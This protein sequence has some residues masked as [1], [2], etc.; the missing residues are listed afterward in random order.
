MRI[1]GIIK[2][3]IDVHTMGINNISSHLELCGYKVIKSNQNIEESTQNI[4][5]DHNYYKIEK[6]LI[7]NEIT[8]LCF[9]YRLDQDFGS[10]VFI[11]LV[12]K[13]I[14]RNLFS[15]NE[16]KK[17]KFLYFAGLVEGCDNITQEFRGGIN[18][19]IGD[20]DIVT[21]LKK[22][23]IPDNRIPNSIIQNTEY[24]LVLKNFGRYILDNELEK[25]IDIKRNF[26][27]SGFGTRKD[28]IIKRIDYAKT[29][30]LL[31]LYRAHIGPYGE[32]KT[33]ALKLFN[34]WLA[35]L[36][37]SNTL[38]IVSIGSSQLTQEKFAESWEGLVNGGGVPIQYEKELY[39]IY[40]ISRPLLLRAYSATKNVAEFSVTLDDS[41]NNAWHAL[42][43][44]WFNKIDGRGELSLID[45]LKEHEQAVKYI[46][47]RQKI[48][49]VNTS[50]HFSFRGGDDVSYIVSVY[51]AALKAKKEGVKIFVLQNM[52]NTPKGVSAI[53]DLAKS[54]AMIRLFSEL[55]DNNFRIIYQPR[56][57]L[58]LFSPFEDIAKQQL[59]SV[60]ALM[61]DIKPIIE[62][63]HVVSYSEG[64]KLADPEVVINSI[65]LCEAA[66]K[67]YPEF[68]LK[69]Y[70]EDI[71]L[72]TDAK[73]RE[74]YFYS[75][76]KKLISYI[77]NNYDKNLDFR[78][79]EEIFR[80]GV[81]PVP[82]LWNDRDIYSKAVNWKTKLI[83][84]G[85]ELVKEDSLN[86]IEMDDRIEILKN[87]RKLP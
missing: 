83:N 6:W 42:S 28:N 48:L 1:F 62:I 63:M 31:P 7:D 14:S 80:D 40:K 84:G 33:E 74:Y 38:D 46:S 30:N 35:I 13:L 60:S 12:K 5:D 87:M 45:S 71:I 49:E 72:N 69:Y 21:T 79:L 70:I 82:Y 20:E 68:R 52:L 66:K 85:V 77:L 86:K 61:Y 17:I 9:S 23:N 41:I 56:A 81:F 37:S 75:D 53:N 55:E 36:A 29:N 43:F 24:D 2:P 67:Y 34:Q 3:K 26:C 65:R 11:Y 78:S 50:H 4:S 64:Y 10:R 39:D 57:G 47:K 44:W 51:L 73:E 32:K 27:Y 15:F 19:F 25:Q 58:G 22:L 16:V 59:V 54:R 8:D 18:T 76:S